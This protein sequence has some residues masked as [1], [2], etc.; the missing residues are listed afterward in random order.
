M[1][2]RNIN[3]DEIIEENTPVAPKPLTNK[4]PKSPRDI[5]A[6][7]IYKP[8][9][10]KNT[11]QATKKIRILPPSP[12]S[13]KYYVN[14]SYHEIKDPQDYKK[15]SNVICKNYS[16]EYKD[17]DTCPIC[18]KYF[19]AKKANDEYVLSSMKLMTIYY[20]NIMV[21]TDKEQPENEGKVFLY[22]MPKDIHKVIQK[23][24]KPTDEYDTKE[25]VYDYTEGRVLSLEI[26][27]EKVPIGTSGKHVDMPTYKASN[28][29]DKSPFSFR[30]KVL[31]DEQLDSVDSKIYK[32][33]NL[34]SDENM[35]TLE[36]CEFVFQYVL[37]E[38]LGVSSEG[39]VKES[40]GASQQPR[41]PQQ[42]TSQGSSE[43]PSTASSTD[44]F[45]AMFSGF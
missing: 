33:E 15:F 43:Q 26:S 21:L 10:D 18:K 30:G 22:R 12:D 28:F 31:T 32:L 23:K 6:G 44:E 39:K 42:N 2:R 36:Q 5:E 16:Y 14:M 8:V 17:M 34:I 37:N 3:W 9:V 19:Q 4:F 11:R 24:I 38:P 25:Y 45:E 27:L 13:K 1:A 35:P 40:T 7:M 29:L 20:Y 41:Q